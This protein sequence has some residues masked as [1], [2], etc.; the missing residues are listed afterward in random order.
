MEQSAGASA[1]IRDNRNFQE[2]LK[3]IFVFILGCGK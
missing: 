2:T 1:S 3:D